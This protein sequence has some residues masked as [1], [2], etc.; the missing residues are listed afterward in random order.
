VDGIDHDLAYRG[1]AA[2]QFDVVDL[3]STDAE[4]RYYNLRVLEDDRRHFPT[5]DAV[6]LYRS[7]LAE[8]APEVVSALGRLEDRITEPLMVALNERSKLRRIPERT[9]AADYLRETFGIE[10][11]PELD[12]RPRRIL[13]RTGEHLFLV[14]VSVAAAIIIAVP[15][16]ILAAKRP[17][18]GQGILTVVGLLQTVPALA[19]FVFLI[20][21][22][23][24]EETPAIC[25]LFLYSL[26]AIVRNT[27][28]GLR[29]IPRPIHESARAL[30]LSPLSRLRMIELPLAAPSIF[31]G[32]KTAVV[33]NVGTATLAAIVGA[34]GYG[35]PILK[36]IRLDRL[37]LILEGAIPAALMA[38]TAQGLFELIESAVVPKGL[39]LKP[40]HAP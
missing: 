7:D 10:T 8:R 13:K 28:A 38:L 26:L 35:Q 36:G 17:V 37:D 40:E 29:G 6:L 3:Y 5:Y 19:M 14:L 20:P 23:G 39:R 27:H 31:A 34:G 25:A 15:L 21:L 32:V 22:V 16:G 24:L 11:E 9:V 1:L 4:I 30:G 33:I 12:T 2:G 18:F